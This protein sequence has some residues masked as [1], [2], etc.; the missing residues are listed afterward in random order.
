MREAAEARREGLPAEL[1]QTR[2]R[3]ILPFGVVLALVI[4]IAGLV[5]SLRQPIQVALMADA[6]LTVLVLLPAVL[7]MMPLVA[8]SVALVAL[9]SRWHLRTRSPLRRL[10]V[11]TAALEA[12]AD[13]WLRAVDGRVLEQAVRIA[14][15]R[16]L[17][18]VFDSPPEWPQDGGENERD[19]K[20]A[21]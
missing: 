9:F 6:M 16:Q 15:L 1:P 14:P 12:K 11:G 2:R 21:N 5:M 4:A 3:V 20:R 17:L 10:E 13:G 8:L 18:R 7:C 19:S